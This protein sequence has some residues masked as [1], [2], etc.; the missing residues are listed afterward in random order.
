[1]FI[2]GLDLGQARDYTAAAIIERLEVKQD[3]LD[4]LQPSAVYHVRRLERTQGT[5]T[6]RRWQGQGDH[7]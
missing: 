3:G 4:G 5:L 7:G 2:I 6:R 1:M